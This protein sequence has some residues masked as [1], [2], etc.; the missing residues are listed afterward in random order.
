MQTSREYNMS[1]IEFHDANPIFFETIFAPVYLDMRPNDIGL[2]LLTG[3]RAS[4]R[5]FARLNPKP[6][7]RYFHRVCY[8]AVRTKNEK[9]CAELGRVRGFGAWRV[10]G[11]AVARREDGYDRIL[12][13]AY[14]QM[15]GSLYDGETMYRGIP[16]FLEGICKS[17]RLVRKLLESEK[18]KKELSEHLQ[19]VA[20]CPDPHITDIIRTLINDSRSVN[21]TDALH[22][23]GPGASELFD[24]LMSQWN[25]DWKDGSLIAQHD[26]TVI[27]PDCRFWLLI[28]LGNPGPCASDLSAKILEHISSYPP[29]SFACITRNHGPDAIRLLERAL[30][31]VKDSPTFD[32]PLMCK[33]AAF[34][35]GPCTMGLYKMWESRGFA[36]PSNLEAAAKAGNKELCAYI[37]SQIPAEEREKYAE[38]ALRGLIHDDTFDGQEEIFDMLH[39]FIPNISL[40]D[41]DLVA[42]GRYGRNGHLKRMIMRIALC[43][44]NTRMTRA[45]GFFENDV[46]RYPNFSAI[47]KVFVPQ[48]PIN[49]R[50]LVLNIEENLI[51]NME[52]RMSMDILLLV[53]KYGN[54]SPNDWSRFIVRL[55]MLS[56][57]LIMPEVFCFAA[58]YCNEPERDWVKMALPKSLMRPT[59]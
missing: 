41:D 22:N 21:I 15:D 47:L 53:K 10:F 32:G 1:L 25:V 38:K 50:R 39:M 12:E 35:R 19:L 13:C 43:I 45:V 52:A 18:N 3:L 40:T 49:E 7:P 29:D 42:C 33:V 30:S 55:S 34:N 14:T 54:F 16:D 9:L 36:Q 51:R 23:H 8:D 46:F 2:Y 31:F 28:A 20:Q 59:S 6:K 26:E 57:P 44:H 11:E 37:I 48:M 5:M 17:P 24:F 4:C 56:V 58:R 27:T